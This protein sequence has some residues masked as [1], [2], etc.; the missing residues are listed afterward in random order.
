MQTD[1]TD[2]TGTRA[3]RSRKYDTY[4]PPYSPV[5]GAILPQD[6][7]PEQHVYSPVYEAPAQP[8]SKP[9]PHTFAPAKK[10]RQKTAADS[11]L[12]GAIVKATVRV[13]KVTRQS[14]KAVQHSFEP[15]HISLLRTRKQRF[16]LRTFYVVG[17]AS[18]L[19]AV[20]VGLNAMFGSNKEPVRNTTGV[21]GVINS[22]TSN[23]ANRISEDPIETRPSKQ[24]FATYL[25]APQYPRYLRIP[26]LSIESRIRRLGLD[27][28]NAVG[29][30]NNIFDAGWYDGSVRPGEKEGSSIIIGHVAGVKEHGLF[31]DLSKITAGSLI[32][33]EKGNGET[34]N[35]KVVK[36]DKLPQ[37]SLDMSAYIKTEVAGKHDLKLITSSGKFEQIG[38]QFSGRVV[39]YAQQQ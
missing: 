8:V 15:P 9:I 34:V 18:F 6:P 13:D 11:A 31:W 12:F 38:A 35:Y 36:I 3:G 21:L 29:S 28:K 24:D 1:N 23:D 20:G 7:A 25:V 5:N 26:S 37:G 17:T 22:Q 39:V 19:F 14:V 2:Q 33:I 4:I 10:H 27:S 32:E 30:P 16:F